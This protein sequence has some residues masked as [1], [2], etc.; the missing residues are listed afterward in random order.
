VAKR[1]HDERFYFALGESLF[2][3]SFD[4]VVLYVFAPGWRRP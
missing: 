1:V 4:A 2:V 3:L